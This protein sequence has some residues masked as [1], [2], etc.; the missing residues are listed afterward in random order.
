MR[1]RSSCLHTVVACARWKPDTETFQTRLVD[2]LFVACSKT[3][4]GL[5]L[6]RFCR[7]EA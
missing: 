3:A 6:L 2:R 5:S 7:P 4:M 1:V